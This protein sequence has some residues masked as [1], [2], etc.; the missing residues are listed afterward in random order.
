MR[1]QFDFSH[2]PASSRR[3]M[4]GRLVIVGIMQIIVPLVAVLVLDSVLILATVLDPTA[5]ILGMNDVLKV[6]FTPTLVVLQP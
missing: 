4:S 3:A 1:E 5:C 6:S 2:V